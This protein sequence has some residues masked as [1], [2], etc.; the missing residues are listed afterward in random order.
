MQGFWYEI[1]T[2]LLPFIFIFNTE[3]LLIDVGGVGHFLVVVVCS[4]IAMGCFVAA[5]QNWLLTRNRWYETLALLLIC[6]TLFRPGYWLD[7]LQAPFDP[8]QPADS[9][10]QRRRRGSAGL[11]LALP[12]QQP[13][14]RRRRGREGRAADHALGQDR[15]RAP[16]SRRTVAGH[17]RRQSH[18][19]DWSAS[20]ARPPNTASPAA[21]RSPPCWCRRIGRAATGLPFPHCCCL[22]ALSFYSAD[23]N[24]LRSPSFNRR[25]TPAVFRVF[26]RKGRY[27]VVLSLGRAPDV[28]TD[29]G[30]RSFDGSCA[31]MWPPTA[32]SRRTCRRRSHWPDE[33]GDWVSNSRELVAVPDRLPRC[34]A[35][36]YCIN[37]D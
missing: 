4:I 28:R 34:L 22:E 26:A 31:F 11:D 35:L 10:L 3:L 37:S 16:A 24:D 18:G 32:E 27:F 6:F 23:G 36:A 19:A 29:D 2:G 12:R 7:Q 1:R 21:T 14:A 33:A 30:S 25:P 5:T 13:V 17:A 15:S 8:Q 20:A 9:Y